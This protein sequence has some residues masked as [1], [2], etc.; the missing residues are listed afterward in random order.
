MK[1]HPENSGAFVIVAEDEQDLLVEVVSYL[2]DH[3]MTVRGVSDG[4]D[5]WLCFGE[6]EPDIVV[7][8]LGLGTEDGSNIAAAVR[9]R[10]PGVGI[11]MTTARSAV[12]DR[13]GGYEAGAD[14][15]LVKPVDLGELS[16][17]IRALYRRHAETDASDNTQ[18]PEWELDLLGWHLTGPDKRHIS[19][20]RAE[21][22]LLDCLTEAPG[23]PVSRF[24]IARHMG[25]SNQLAS[26]RFVD[27]VVYRLRHKIETELDLEAPLGS[28]HNQGYFFA[29]SVLRKL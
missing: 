2:S 8:D 19:L 18:A 7:L 22:Q 11:I 1:E 16:A 27:Q 9:Q 29:R 24:D 10:A 5:F 12:D 25:K 15:Y 28:A 17:A 26:H 6:R 4:P 21:T 14:I 20:T 3:G 13:I 23:R